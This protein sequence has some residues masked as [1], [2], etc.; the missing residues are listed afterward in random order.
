MT[1]AQEAK[2]KAAAKKAAEK[3]KKQAGEDDSD[4]ENYTAPSR[5]AGANGAKPLPGNFADC[6]KCSKQFT[7]VT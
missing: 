1:K 7:V 4:D 2:A 5:S 6:A 3:K